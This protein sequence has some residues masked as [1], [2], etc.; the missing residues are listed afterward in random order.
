VVSRSGGGG[1]QSW[2]PPTPK[3]VMGSPSAS[4]HERRRVDDDSEITVHVRVSYK[5]VLLVVVVFD[6]VHL[7]LREMVSSS[8]L[9]RLFGI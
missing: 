2:V 7:S 5:T 3:G 6:L 8:F 4:R 1:E 9:E